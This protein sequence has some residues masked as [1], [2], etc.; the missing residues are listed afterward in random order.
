MV[1]IIARQTNGLSP[2]LLTEFPKLNLRRHH[3]QGVD[4]GGAMSAYHTIPYET[5]KH[6]WGQARSLSRATKTHLKEPTWAPRSNCATAHVLESLRMHRGTRRWANLEF[7]CF[8][9]SVLPFTSTS[10]VMKA[11]S[12]TQKNTFRNVADKYDV[13]LLIS[14]FTALALKFIFNPFPFE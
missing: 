7:G 6:A 4:G 11:I 12:S 10:S 9:I 14:P 5:S 1:L 2:S 13:S 3:V 8:I